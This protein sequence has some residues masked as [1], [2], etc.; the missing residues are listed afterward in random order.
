M[1]N[2]NELAQSTGIPKHKLLGLVRTGKIIGTR[3][4]GRT[5]HWEFPDDTPAKIASIITLKPTQ[6]TK[7][8][9]LGADWI[10]TRKAANMLH[11][12]I[13]A[14]QKRIESKNLESKRIQSRWFV[15]LDQIENLRQELKERLEIRQA[16]ELSNFTKP[17]NELNRRLLRLAEIIKEVPEMEVI[18]LDVVLEIRSD[19]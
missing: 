15:R 12:S 7:I 13:D 2:M 4:P 9:D 6:K 17:A 3:N 11:L 1:Y 16:K 18:K 10:T 19:T 5:G 8:F 14:I